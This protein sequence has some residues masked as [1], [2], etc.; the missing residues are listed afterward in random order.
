MPTTNTALTIGDK[1]GN[2]S[3]FVA[4]NYS[5]NNNQPITFINNGFGGRFPTY[6]PGGILS[7]NAYGIPNYIVGAGSVVPSAV[8]PTSLEKYATCGFRYFGEAVLRLTAVDEPED[9][10][11]MDV[12]T[13]GSVMHAVLERFFLEQQATKRPA[14]GEPWTPGDEA[15]IVALLDEELTRIRVEGR[16]G[17]A[18]FLERDRQA[19]A[20]LGG[21]ATAGKR[22]YIAPQTE[23]ERTI[24]AIWQ[25]AL[26]LEQVGIHDNFFDLGGQSLLMTQVQGKLRATL[27]RDISM[28]DMFKYPTISA[29]AAYLS[30]GQPAPAAPA[31]ADRGARQREAIARQRQQALR[32]RNSDD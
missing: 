9:L 11:S 26:R 12:M 27:K 21:A 5:W 25:S 30:E 31:T 6:S 28:V 4:L 15:R 7:F 10:E 18:V 1:I 32:R 22:R 29:L 19:L 13:R 23:I 8:S 14:V 24:A 2:L 3:Y 20:A 17:L 16:S